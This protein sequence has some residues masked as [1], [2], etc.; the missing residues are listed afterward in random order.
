MRNSLNLRFLFVIPAM[1]ALVFAVWGG[2]VRLGWNVPQLRGEMFASH[3]A[4]MVCGFFGTLICTERAVALGKLVGYVVPGLSGVAAIALMFGIETAKPLFCAAS[5]GLL[6]VSAYIIYIQPALYTLIEALGAVC[7]LIGNIFWLSAE[8]VFEVVLWWAGF[9]LLTV[10]GERLDLSR[11]LQ[12]SRAAQMLFIASVLTFISGIAVS[13]FSLDSGT[14]ICGFGFFAVSL[15]LLI[16]DIAR[17]TIK[18]EGLPRFVAVCLLAGYFWLTA[19]GAMMTISGEK[20]LGTFYDPVLHSIFLGF[21][22]SMI[23]G[24]APIIFPAISG[25]R[26]EFTRAFYWHLVLLH[27][28]VALRVG[29]VNAESV[30][31]RMLA[32]VL[33]AAAII[34]FVLN[35]VFATVRK[36]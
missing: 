5:A 32:G 28:S 7:W 6:V 17:R 3:G 1:L 10:A 24:H 29:S 31:A 12:Y 22:M 15:W 2:L 4:L 19:A 13:R 25:I 9:L 14:R 8:P 26:M 21:V 35:T 34:L 16:N 27:A 18:Q 23:F 30:P 36:R 33:N 11:L 20:S